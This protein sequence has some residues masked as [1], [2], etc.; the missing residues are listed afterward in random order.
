MTWDSQA[1]F[2][3]LH[4]SAK[5]GGSFNRDIIAA[6]FSADWINKP[7]LVEAFPEIF[8]PPLPGF[9]EE[10]SLGPRKR[11]AYLNG[12]GASI[13]AMRNGW[14]EVAV[15]KDGCVCYDTPLTNDVERFPT[16]EEAEAFAIKI[17]QL[18]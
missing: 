5:M 1:N 10:T 12:Y 17:S 16:L 15:L 11:T 2:D 7:R 8:K 3:R 18:P 4:E 9:D 6:F 14:F 13:I